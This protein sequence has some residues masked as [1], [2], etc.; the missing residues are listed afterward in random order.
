MFAPLELAPSGKYYISPT[1][2]PGFLYSSLLVTKSYN[3]F[4]KIRPYG[5]ANT[6]TANDRDFTT[7]L[8]SQ[9]E[10]WKLEV[11]KT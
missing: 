9:R 2:L 10:G 5:T 11:G 7:G 4:K 3:I 8:F 1:R 6:K